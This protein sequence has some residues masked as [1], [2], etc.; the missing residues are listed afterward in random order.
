M[1]KT[2]FDNFNEIQEYIMGIKTQNILENESF[3]FQVEIMGEGSGIFYIEHKNN[4]L[5]VKPYDYHDHSAHIQAS[6][7]IIIELLQG[8][9]NINDAIRFDDIN[10]ISRAN[11]GIKKLISFFDAYYK[12]NSSDSVRQFFEPKSEYTNPWENIRVYIEHSNIDEESKKQLLA[13]LVKFTSQELHILI[14]GACGCGKSS[15]INA[16]FNMDVAQV[17]YGVDP[18]TQE[19]SIYKLDNLYL[20][21]SP[22]LGESTEKDKEHIKKI[23]DALQEK[24]SNGNGVIDVVLVIVDGSHRDMKSSFELI[25]NVIIPNLQHKDRILIGI[26]RCDLAL[27]GYGWIEK[28]NYP[29]EELLQRLKEKSESVR[30]R[31]KNDTGVDVEPVFYSALHMYNI[32]KLLSYLV[33]S[34]PIK[35]RVFFAEKINKNPDN[36]LRDDTVTLKKRNCDLE[37]TEMPYTS[38]SIT[39]VYNTY[40]ESRQI[41]EEV[42][43]IRSTINGIE[44]KIQTIYADKKSEQKSKSKELNSIAKQKKYEQPKEKYDNY[45]SEYEL[46]KTNEAQYKKQFRTSMEE[47]FESASTEISK[48]SKEKIKL[49]FVNVLDNVK[50]SAKAGAELGKEIGQNVPFIGVAVGGAVGAVI[51]GVG[52]LFSSMFK[53]KKR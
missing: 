37:S 24:D 41:E 5:T 3:A 43:Q 38:P 8:K 50:E 1:E 12:I 46:V 52:G 22:G 45:D 42:E 18:E 36:F 14:V 28:Y 31:I 27:N 15:T 13:N 10:I 47:A 39:N 53:R 20:H 25:N 51:G 4:N 6:A 11:D 23:K 9:I 7:E 44:K 16:L 49:S 26:N 34:A 48:G 2:F 35:K 21:D 40:T 32:S 29:N 30:N 33:K 17:G 19:V